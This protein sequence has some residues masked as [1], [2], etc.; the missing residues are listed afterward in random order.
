MKDPL[1]LLRRFDE[2]PLLERDPSLVSSH[3]PFSHLY[4]AERF[5]YGV[6]GCNFELL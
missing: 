6:R 1:A 4:F 2:Q 5:D 3:C